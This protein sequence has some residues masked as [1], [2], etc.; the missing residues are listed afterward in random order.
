MGWDRLTRR[1]FVG[2]VAA[3]AAVLGAPSVLFASPAV[4]RN[5]VGLAQD[6]VEITFHHIWGTPPGQAAKKKSPAE[7]VIDLFNAKNTGVKVVSRTDSGSYAEVLQKTQAELAAG[8]SPA[9]VSTPWANINWAAEGLGLVDLD[10]V[11][12]DELDAVLGN[13]REDVIPLVQ[14]DGRTK[15]LPYAFS[16]PVIYYNQDML[17]DAGIDPAELLSDWDVLLNDLGPKLGEAVGGPVLGLTDG[18]WPAQGIAQ[19]NGGFVMNDDNVFVMDSP[20][21]IGAMAMIAALDA[22]GILNRSTRAEE[23]ASF[24]GGSLPVYYA[25]IASLSNLRD[26]VGF[27][28]GVSTFPTFGEKERLMSSGGSFIGLFAQE[29]DQQQAAWEFLKFAA[30]EEGYTPWAQM[31][32]LNATTF[33]MPVLDGQEAAYTQL[34]E[35]VTRETPWPTERGGE[36]AAIWAQ[37]VARIWTNDISAEEGCAE[38]AAE[39]NAMVGNG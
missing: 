32:Y 24:I 38:V 23:T 10:D 2:S 16:N 30:S 21:T 13:L 6:T 5:G 19:S 29:P 3:G 1:R 33:D 15:G 20:E 27:S 18:Q 8:N 35:G 31:G 34:E 4:L 14:I 12:G 25:S 36:L 37:M 9:L 17:D 7:E 22:A 26:Q 39:L 28:M 11:A